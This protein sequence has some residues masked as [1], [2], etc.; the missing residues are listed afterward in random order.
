MEDTMAMT[1]AAALPAVGSS[2]PP[3]HVAGVTARKKWG[4]GGRHG[5]EESDVE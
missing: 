2:T 5:V 1:A 4:S 3:P